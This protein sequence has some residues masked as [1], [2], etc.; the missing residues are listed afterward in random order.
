[1]ATGIIEKLVHLS[2]QTEIPSANLDARYNFRGYGYIR[3]STAAGDG[4]VFFAPADLTNCRFADISEGDVVEFERYG[5]LN[6]RAKSVTV[7]KW[8]EDDA[9]A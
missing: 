8:V 5:D 9:D 6:K 4:E 1:M 7:L 2:N 3:P